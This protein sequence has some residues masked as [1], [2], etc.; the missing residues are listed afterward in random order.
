MVAKPQPDHAAGRTKKLAGLALLGSG[1]G[2][3][4]LG[5]VFVGLA[6][7]ANDDVENPADGTHDPS[8]LMLQSGDPGA[9]ALK[10]A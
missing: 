1:A 2:L 9:A 5:A 7:V 6:K 3:V 4:A 10:P 8:A